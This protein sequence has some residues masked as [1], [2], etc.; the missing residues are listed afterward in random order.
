MKANL[1]FVILAWGPVLALA[2]VEIISTRGT[3]RQETHGGYAIPDPYNQLSL[4]SLLRNQSIVNELG[5]TEEGKI[6][7]KEAFLKNRG[8]FSATVLENAGHLSIEEIHVL[9]QKALDESK[10]FLDEILA[11]PQW[12]RLKQLAFQTEVA[13]VGMGK[14]LT[15]GQLGKAVGVYENQVSHI[16]ERAADIEGR[17]VRA[18]TQLL[19][20]AQAELIAELSTEQQAKAKD[21]MG[22]AFLYRENIFQRGKL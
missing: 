15:E 9:R 19:V 14:A 3:I 5:V 8:S 17:T 12:E 16:N 18:I 2:Q 4:A 21:C 7:L 13:K 10:L 20:E 1:S 22:K 11:P 6:K